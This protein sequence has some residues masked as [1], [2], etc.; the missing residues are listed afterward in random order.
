MNIDVKIKKLRHNAVIPQYATSGSAGV[1][2]CYAGDSDIILK[3]GERVLVPCGFSIAI[4][5]PN[6]VALMYARSGISLKHGVTMANGVGVIDSDYRGEVKCPMINLGDED[7]IIK[8][9]DRVGQLVFTPIFRA[10]L[11]ECDT[12]DETE[13]GGGGFGSTGR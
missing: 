1:D 6:V 9:G 10:T 3:R 7:Y 13:R 2:V 12:L 5:S 4:S 11:T 8:P